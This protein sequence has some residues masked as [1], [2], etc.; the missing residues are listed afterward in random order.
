MIHIGFTISQREVF[1]ANGQFASDGSKFFDKVE[2][3][4]AYF[5][6]LNQELEG[7]V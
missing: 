5:Y 3:V 7:K 2:D 4:I 1:S 6:R